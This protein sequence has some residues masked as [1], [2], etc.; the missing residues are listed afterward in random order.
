MYAATLPQMNTPRN[1]LSADI[2]HAINN[3]LNTLVISLSV[4]EAQ[5]NEDLSDIITV[6]QADLDAL[7]ALLQQLDTLS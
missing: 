4:L 5:T 3:R 1:A 6:M 7:Q 2:R